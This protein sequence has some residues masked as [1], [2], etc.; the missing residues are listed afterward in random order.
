MHDLAIEYRDPSELVAFQANART[1]S[2]K[3]I[4]QIAESMRRFGFTNPVLIDDQG[5][6]LAGHGRVQASHL[7][8]LIRSLASGFLA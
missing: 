3:Q 4:Q 5:M 8:K 1:H 6:I 7:L 2:K